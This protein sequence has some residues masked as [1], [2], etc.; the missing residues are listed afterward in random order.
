[1]AEGFKT[2]NLSVLS[3]A[4][5]HTQWHFTTPDTAED[6]ESDGYFEDASHMLA[7]GDL[8]T[9]NADRE[10]EMKTLLRAVSSSGVSGVKIKKPE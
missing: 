6:V 9:I 10:G 8:L 3:Y 1:M 5:G 2:R 7:K 4:N